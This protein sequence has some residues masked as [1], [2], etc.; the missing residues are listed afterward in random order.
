MKLMIVDD[1]KEIRVFLRSSFKDLTE[2]IIECSDGQT[3]VELYDEH[4]PDY[5]LMDIEMEIMDGLTATKIIIAKHSEA[6]II[7]VTSHTNSKFYKSSKLAGAIEFV[8]KD[9]LFEL[10]NIINIQNKKRNIR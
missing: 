5:V 10:E 3:A 6:K 4:L 9:N 2:E 7:I 1:N 8:S